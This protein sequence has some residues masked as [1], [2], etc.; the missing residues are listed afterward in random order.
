MLPRRH[1][2]SDTDDQNGHRIGN[3]GNYGTEGQLERA[4][5]GLHIS[6]LQES[7]GNPHISLESAADRNARVLGRAQPE[8][9]RRSP[10]QSHRSLRPQFQRPGQSDRTKFGRQQNR[11]AA[12]WCFQTS[13]GT[14]DIDTGTKLFKRISAS[15]LFKVN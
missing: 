1:D 7:S 6:E 14:K 4:H 2:R 12:E 13:I 3:L 15:T 8:G 11:P 5:F 10:Q 9:A